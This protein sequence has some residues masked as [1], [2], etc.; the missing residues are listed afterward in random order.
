MGVK[1]NL[2]TKLFRGIGLSVLMSFGISTR[3]QADNVA[4]FYALDAD[5]KA[6]RQGMAKPPH[7]IRVGSR[8]ISCWETGVHRLFAVKMEPGAIQT[9][10][11]AQAVM[12]KFRC[13]YAVSS[14]PVGEID[15]K[16][17]IGEWVLV[18]RVIPYQRG[19]EGQA[20]FQ[21]SPD[22][23]RGIRLATEGWL[24]P[25]LKRDA[26]VA[27][28]SG[29]VFCASSL[30]RER[31]AEMAGAAVIDMNLAGLAA[32]CADH[33]VPLVAWRVVSDHADEHADE[34]F[35]AFATAYEGQGGK[36]VIE[37]VRRLPKNENDP[38]SYGNLDSLLKE[39]P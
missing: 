21:M 29:E 34:D 4:F 3:A 27:V 6:L 36:W 1:V 22:A 28:A 23:A 26:P 39:K 33:G 35:R 8:E 17:R 2:V 12:G 19:S 24:P 15:G 13:D 10:I 14:G 37:F 31:L 11:S 5:M 7:R 18:D 38:S 32:V 20:G 25:S 16:R 30:F 9:A